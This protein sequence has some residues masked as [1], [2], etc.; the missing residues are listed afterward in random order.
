MYLSFSVRKRLIASKKRATNCAAKDSKP[1]RKRESVRSNSQMGCHLQSGNGLD[2]CLSLEPCFDSLLILI[3]SGSM[4]P[5]PKSLFDKTKTK[6]SQLQKNM[7]H[8]RII[9][10]MPNNTRAFRVLSKPSGSTMP[11]LPPSSDTSRVTVNTVIHRRPATASTSSS[12]ATSSPAMKRPSAFST[13]K[14]RLAVPA[15]PKPPSSSGSSSWHPTVGPST[16][17]HTRSPATGHTTPS[18]PSES[19][20]LKPPTPAKRDPMA[21]LFVPKRRTQSQRPV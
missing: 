14:S 21:S 12:V 5:Q 1:R 13:T 8:A 9:P 2:V 10:P 20:P 15:T 7:Y 16:N 11:L 19:R 18:K 17:N 6:T 3:P 4:N